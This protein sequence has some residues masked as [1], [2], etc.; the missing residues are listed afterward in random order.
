MSAGKQS[1]GYHTFEDLYEHRHWLF[2][3]FMLDYSG[4]AW[5][6][7]RHSD[8]SKLDGWFIAG[9][10]LPGEGQVSYHLPMRFWPAMVAFGF[11]RPKAPKWDGHTSRDVLERLRNRAAAQ[12]SVEF[13]GVSEDLSSEQ[14]DHAP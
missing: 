8:G 11:D 1:D 3:H 10:D 7:Q 4:L 13:P 14:V 6:S 12:C 2:V 9:V 5:A